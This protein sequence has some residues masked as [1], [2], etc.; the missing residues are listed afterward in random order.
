M[1]R[2]LTL[3]LLMCS[4]WATPIL[5]QTVASSRPEPALAFAAGTIRIEF[6]AQNIPQGRSGL[7]RV[8]GVDVS[9]VT[10]EVFLNPISFFTVPGDAG[11]YAFVVPQLDQSARAYEMALQVT[12]GNTLYPIT[13]PVN[14]SNGRF[15]RQDVTLRDDQLDLLDPQV[16]GEELALIESMTAANTPLRYWA[17]TKF[18]LPTRAPAT[19]P[20][21]LVRVFNSTFETRHT[22]WDFQGDLGDALLAMADGRVIYTGELAIR[23]NYLLLDHGY[24][25]YTGYAHLGAFNVRQGQFVRQG[26]VIGLAGNTGRST[27]P[28]LHIEM[29]VNGHWVDPLD[30]LALWLP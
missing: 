25:I 13:V 28:H 2:T 30:F 3:L 26:Q 10:G 18:A 22:G 21:G 16:E 20:F 24:G 7:V 29:R 27:S 6:Y 15:L 9:H 19:S 17:R 14:V 1:K 12:Q 5:A 4:L 11:F 23:G 8:S